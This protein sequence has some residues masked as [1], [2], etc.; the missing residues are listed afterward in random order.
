M[1]FGQ[2]LKFGSK[3]IHNATSGL[4][5]L[6]AK[7]KHGADWI[8][9]TAQHFD[10]TLKSQP[11]IGS[12]YE[13]MKKQPIQQLGGKSLE[14][15]G[16]LGERGLSTAERVGGALQSRSMAEA[17]GRIR[18]LARDLPES[19]RMALERG[20]GFAEGASRAVRRGM[21]FR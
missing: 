2:L 16:Q 10:K 9:G 17:S 5:F 21:M 11:I 13:R 6:G 8:R 14:E 20:V 3:A 18:G 4:N 12:L 19:Q 15:V 1:V 7:I